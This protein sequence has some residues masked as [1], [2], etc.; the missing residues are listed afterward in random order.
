M[1]ALWMRGDGVSEEMC[2]YIYVSVYHIPL[3]ETRTHELR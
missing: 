1:Y 3:G 2:G